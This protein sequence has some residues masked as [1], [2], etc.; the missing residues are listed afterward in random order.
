[1]PI[2]ASSWGW[3]PA[4]GRAVMDP[5][6]LDGTAAL[7][8]AL[9]G[10]RKQFL[11]TVHAL[12]PRLHR[13]CAR[14]SGSP[15]DGEDLVQ[16]TLAQAYYALPRLEDP[17]RFEP[18]LFRIAHNKCID[19]LRRER[20][21]REDTV[22]YDD[23]RFLDD[24]SIDDEFAGQPVDEA[25]AALVAQLPPMERAGLLLKD[26]LDNRLGEIAEIVDSTLGGVK[27]ALHR[28]RGKLRAMRQSERTI[29]LDP[30]ERR[31]LEAYAACFNRHDWDALRRLIQADARV[32]M[33]GVTETSATTYFH[34]YS[35]LPWSWLF[36][37]AR[38]DGEPVLVLSRNI[39]GAWRPHSA[40]RVW[41][42]DGK[43]SR[44]RDYF[45]A[46][47]VLADARTELDSS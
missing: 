13:F 7:Q 17:S 8:A 35:A 15:L 14:M 37:L 41:W 20:R 29:A 12:R 40:V 22:E 18:W 28:G 36:S 5:S 47:Y 39:A 30:E 3:R 34:N 27:S 2:V 25:L 43:V 42:R 23:E 24:S 11:A 21:L 44:I 9:E 33:V 45:H 16:E 31:L 19:F 32:E 6:S 1:F 46:D 26:V 4:P 10:T 38:V